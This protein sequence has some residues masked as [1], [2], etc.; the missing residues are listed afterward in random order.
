MIDVQSQ[1]SEEDMRDRMISCKR[2]YGS[3]QDQKLKQHS[4]PLRDNKLPIF[5]LVQSIVIV[6]RIVPQHSLRQIEAIEGQSSQFE[7]RCKVRI[8]QVFKEK[9]EWEEEHVEGDKKHL[10]EVHNIGHIFMDFY[11]Y[12]LKKPCS[13]IGQN[14]LKGTISDGFS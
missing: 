3:K 6:H 13:F 8:G 1:T 12:I 10:G 7:P 4:H 5:L 9:R 2:D 11:L 14:V